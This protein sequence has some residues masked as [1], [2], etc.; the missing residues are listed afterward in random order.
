MTQHEHQNVSNKE[1][2]NTV[3]SK[4]PYKTLSLHD[5]VLCLS[6]FVLRFWR[7]KRPQSRSLCLLYKAYIC[8]R[9][10]R[11]VTTHLF[12]KFPNN[13]TTR[14]ASMV[15]TR[16]G[17]L[18]ISNKSVNARDTS[19]LRLQRRIL[20]CIRCRIYVIRRSGTRSKDTKNR[21]LSTF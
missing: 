10:L 17:I 5:R 19:R 15:S 1:S 9:H 18:T 3:H 16:F 2:Y 6:F 7:C 14:Q 20:T 13:R 4:W 11:I 21:R 12:N 8:L